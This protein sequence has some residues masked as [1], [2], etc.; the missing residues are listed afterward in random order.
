MAFS[1]GGKGCH[2]TIQVSGR[3]NAVDTPIRGE[4]SP[5]TDRQP[6][7]IIITARIRKE[8]QVIGK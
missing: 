1:K 2:V 8:P 3:I 4:G 6:E 5:S 7:A